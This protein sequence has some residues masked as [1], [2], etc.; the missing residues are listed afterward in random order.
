M[1]KSFDYFKTLKDL[2]INVFES[3]SCL[4]DSKAL[5]KNYLYFLAS[6]NEL[7]KNLI[8]EFVAPIERNDIYI[9]SSCLSEEF[10]C[11]VKLCEFLNLSKTGFENSLR[12]ICSL[13][14]KQSEIFDFKVL[15]KA[16]QRGL[17][18]ISDLLSECKKIKK[19]IAN[20]TCDS[21]YKGNQPLVFY[22]IGSSCIETVSTIERTLNEI[23][24]VLIN[25]S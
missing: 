1:K 2:S 13:F 6:K 15:L 25:N 4:R 24:R 11:V 19:L 16:P 21:I 9:L 10:N 23:C 5:N 18:T 14:N 22:I 12:L 20:E 8:D 3:F 17:G 7:S